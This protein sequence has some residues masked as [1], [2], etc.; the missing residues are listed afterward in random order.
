MSLLIHRNRGDFS[1]GSFPAGEA[2]EDWEFGTN[3]EV[4]V[5]SV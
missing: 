5:N 3:P 4:T 2:R 1:P